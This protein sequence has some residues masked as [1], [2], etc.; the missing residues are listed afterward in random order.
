[1][2]VIDP[3]MPLVVTHA[4]IAPHITSLRWRSGRVEYPTLILAAK[5]EV[6]AKMLLVTRR[7]HAELQR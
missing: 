7:L 2:V 5:M 6:L 1:M 3:M 4:V